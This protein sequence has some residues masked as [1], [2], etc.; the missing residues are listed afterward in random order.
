MQVVPAPTELREYSLEELRPF[1]GTTEIPEGYAASP[2][3]V[4]IKGKASH[5]SREAVGDAVRLGRIPDGGLR[6]KSAN[7]SVSWRFCCVSQCLFGAAQ[8]RLF[9][10][11]IDR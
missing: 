8:P 5:P 1:N 10:G 7:C 9:C 6:G 3:Y 4:G 11:S 2:I